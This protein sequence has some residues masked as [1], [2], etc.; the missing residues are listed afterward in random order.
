MKESIP[1]RVHPVHAA[2]NP[3]ICADDNLAP[4]ISPLPSILCC[5]IV[6]YCIKYATIVTDYTFA[7][8]LVGRQSSPNVIA[9]ALRQ[10][11]IE[12]KLSPGQ[13]LRQETL[14]NHFEVSRIPVREALRQLE[15][16]GWVVFERNRGARVSSL[17][18]EEVREI[19]E[20]R[21]SLEV[22]ALSMASAHHTPQT[23][24]K[25][26]EILRHSR[27]NHDHA[28][29]VTTNRDF[30]LALYGP[31]ARP[32]LLS[33][34]DSLHSQ[35]ERYLRLKL[36]I[37]TYKR[38][39]DDEHEQIVNA[40]QRED[41]NAAMNL[42]RAHFAA[43]RKHARRV[44]ERSPR[45]AQAREVRGLEGGLTTPGNVRSWTTRRDEKARRLAAVAAYAKGKVLEAM[46][47]VAA[48]ERLIRPNDR[49][50]LEG[51]NQK[52]ADFLSRSLVQVDPGVL[53]DIHLLI[54]TLSRPEHLTLFERGIARKL[55]FSFAGPQSLRVAQL[56]E[57]GKLQLGAIHTYVELYARMFVDLTPAR[58]FG[59]RAKR[60]RPGQ[61]LYGAQYRRHT[62]HR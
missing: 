12:G 42:L 56:L 30:H 5:S 8:P 58:G 35:G 7:N 57:D 34:V 24:A 61:S 14:A 1:S 46:H 16:E 10:A 41:T 53:H 26:A 11:I 15:S 6:G 55:D 45:V 2:Q 4:A 25:A 36:D 43:Y 29:F 50:A 40:L 44:S 33:L 49:V 17:S 47:I 18:A 23:L 13:T 38:Q 31:A 37:P 19:Y 3:E 27:L 32:R 21:A 28:S 48:L 22:T 59:V 52:Q 20:I 54:S 51:N 39:S 62:D 9:E 60:G